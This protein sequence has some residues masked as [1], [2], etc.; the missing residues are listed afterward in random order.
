MTKRGQLA[1]ET[2]KPRSRSN[3]Q[4]LGLYA[5]ESQAYIMVD[6]RYRRDGTATGADIPTH[7]THRLPV[8]GGD[9]SID[10]AR[11][12]EIGMPCINLR[13]F[14]TVRT[15][16]SASNRAQRSLPI[17]STK[18]LTIQ[19]HGETAIPPDAYATDVTYTLWDTARRKE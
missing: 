10:R 1:E 5:Q 9:C 17:D 6:H 15:A 16:E 13:H 3:T 7:P 19:H 4:T 2:R 11:K 18:Q 12:D 14:L 8:H